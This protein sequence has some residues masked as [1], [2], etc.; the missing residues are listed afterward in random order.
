[1]TMPWIKVMEA[2]P[3]WYEILL[4]VLGILVLYFLGKKMDGE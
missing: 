1:M 3:T 4:V 2:A